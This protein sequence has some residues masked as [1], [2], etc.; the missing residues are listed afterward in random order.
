MLLPLVCSGTSHS[1]PSKGQIFRITTQMSEL[2]LGTLS[3]VVETASA[4]YKP[5]E[6]FSP[7]DLGVSQTIGN[8]FQRFDLG[9]TALGIAVTRPVFK[10]IQ[11]RV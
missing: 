8:A 11:Y 3:N 9:I 1:C 2:R 5:Q 10:V 7:V 4:W 6:H